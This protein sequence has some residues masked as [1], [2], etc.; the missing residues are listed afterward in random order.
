MINRSH[1]DDRILGVG[2]DLV[3]IDRIK[4]LCVRYPERFLHRVFSPGE[5]NESRG[6]YAYLAGRFA[7]KESVLKAMGT[8]LSNGMRWTEIETITLP[9]GLPETRCT[10]QTANHMEF[11]GVGEIWVSISHDMG[12]ATAFVVLTGG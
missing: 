1:R 7:V 4:K 11:R 3:S 9:N 6:K 5:I 10:G 8:G 12:S 2:I